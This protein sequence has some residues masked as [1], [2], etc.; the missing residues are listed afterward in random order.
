MEAGEGRGCGGGAE[1]RSAGLDFPDSVHVS[2]HLD[3]KVMA[4]D[5]FHCLSMPFA[6]IDDRERESLTMDLKVMDSM[7]EEAT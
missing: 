2:E 1:K 3:L 6:V 5:P 4:L 7:L